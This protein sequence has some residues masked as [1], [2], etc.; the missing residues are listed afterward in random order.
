M[1]IDCHPLAYVSFVRNECERK[2]KTDNLTVHAA[3]TYAATFGAVRHAAV[4]GMA[5]C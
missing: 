1:R 4:C 2:E 5:A 3:R